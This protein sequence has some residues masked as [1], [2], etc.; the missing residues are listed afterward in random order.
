MK[1]RRFFSSLG[2]VALVAA[3]GGGGLLAA[4]AYVGA[5][6]GF[7]EAGE[8]VGANWIRT[9]PA[10]T[11]SFDTQQPGGV[12][13]LFADQVAEYPVLLT[14]QATQ[15][16]DAT[17]GLNLAAR[18]DGTQ[19]TLSVPNNAQLANCLSGSFVDEQTIRLNTGGT[20]TLFR[21]ALSISPQ[22]DEG[23][24]TNIDRTQQRLRFR[25][26]AVVD[27][28]GLFS[29]TG[30]EFSGNSQ[31]GSVV[32]TYRQGNSNAG[33]RLSIAAIAITRGTGSETWTDG[34]LFG[35]SGIQIGGAGGDTVSLQ[36]RNETLACN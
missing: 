3:C 17:N 21:N 2:P 34:R 36:R 13:N 31:S 15:C 1:I 9:D 26:D 20:G 30:C 14:S 10:Q 32:I 35:A 16:G 6:G 12:N 11:M 8:Q 29:Q 28:T 23:V 4:L 25:D 19:M 27:G 24:W 18:L 7:W 5:I 22:F 33:V